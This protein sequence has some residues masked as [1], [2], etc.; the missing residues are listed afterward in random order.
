MELEEPRGE[1]ADPRGHMTALPRACFLQQP[2]ACGDTG[3]ASRAVP[4]CTGP[5][6]LHQG[7]GFPGRVGPGQLGGR[8]SLPS[9]CVGARERARSQDAQL[10][11]DCPAHPVGSAH[12]HF[13]ESL[14]SRAA[15]SPSSPPGGSRGPR[16]ARSAAFI[17]ALG[18]PGAVNSVL[19]AAHPSTR[20]DT[21]R[22][23]RPGQT[24][25][26][27]ARGSRP[28]QAHGAGGQARLLRGKSSPGAGRVQRRWASLSW[29]P[30]SCGF[31]ERRPGAAA[32]CCPG[33][34]Q[35][36][37]VL[38]GQTARVLCLPPA[39]SEDPGPRRLA[40]S[41]RPA[42]SGSVNAGPRQKPQVRGLLQKI[43]PTV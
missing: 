26:N 30:C 15:P 18:L 28:T 38:G 39:A 6:H 21:G 14:H 34:G 4:E 31:V 35:R 32:A 8:A 12:G 1:R 25:A 11:G 33:R 13:P 5:G 19:P 23:G 40:L 24:G 22:G 20:P 29:T 43:T 17:S 2:Q 7:C 37:H 10:P 3:L 42:P 41:E 36:S 27:P 9:V 16:P